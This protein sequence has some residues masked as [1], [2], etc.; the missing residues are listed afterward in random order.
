MTG[1]ISHWLWVTTPEFYAGPDGTDSLDLDPASG[2]DSD[3][4]WTCHRDT[5][6]GDLALLWRTSPRR[7]IAYLMQ[8]KSDAYPI[9]AQPEA[10][11]RGWSFGCEYIIRAKF[12]R[13]LTLAELRA[14]PYLEEW[15]ALRG[16]LQRSVF[17]IP[18]AHWIRLVRMIEKKNPGAAKK[19]ETAESRRMPR[20]VLREEQIE[21]HLA[22]DLSPFIRH[23]HHL[24]LRG[25]QTVCSGNGGR[26][27]LLCYDKRSQRFVIVEL[28]NVR[29]SRNTFGQISSYVGWVAKNMK[30]RKRPVGIVVAQGADP[31]FQDAE[32]TTRGIQFIDLKDL[33]FKQGSR[34]AP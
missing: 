6:Q 18:D 26:I 21:N 32:S 17:A 31:A 28:K 22:E 1:R 2:V 14:E 3:A 5:K 13:P 10:R 29:A 19:F 27:D 34:M 12:E 25:R 20:R 15:S 30:A 23:G 4:W 33:G 8:A 9:A 7:D 24:E 16:N 11:K